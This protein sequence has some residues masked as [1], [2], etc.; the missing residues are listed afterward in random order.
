MSNLVGERGA[1]VVQIGYCH[2]C[3]RQVE[4]DDFTC[5]ICHN[6]FVELFDFEHQAQQPQA[7]QPQQQPQPQQTQEDPQRVRVE[8]F[9]F[10]ESVFNKLFNK[11][12]QKYPNHLYISL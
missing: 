2:T 11:I 9:R 5:S 8:T 10:N 6:G 1:G 7:Q 4:I 12:K 3:D